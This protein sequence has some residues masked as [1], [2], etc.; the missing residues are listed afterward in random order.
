MRQIS[1][2]RVTVQGR[3]FFWTYTKGE[4]IGYIES[5]HKTGLIFTNQAIRFRETSSNLSTGNPI[6][7][8]LDVKLGAIEKAKK[9]MIQKVPVKVTFYLDVIGSPF[10]ADFLDHK[11]ISNIVSLDEEIINV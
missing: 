7:F 8:G 9:Y 6:E 3:R 1:L 4:A 11:Y 10:R 5:V 2:K